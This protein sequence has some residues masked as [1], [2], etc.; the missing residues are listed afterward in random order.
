[1][2]FVIFFKYHYDICFLLLYF[3]MYF[4]QNSANVNKIVITC[5]ELL[6]LL[7]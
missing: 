2:L 6:E 1:M 3:V 5:V 4:K 7:N